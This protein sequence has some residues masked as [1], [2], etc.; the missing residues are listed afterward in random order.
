MT[1]ASLFSEN[2]ERWSQF[3]P[4]EADYLKHLVCNRISIKPLG[5]ELN[6]TLE[7]E[8]KVSFYHENDPIEEAK[9]WFEQLDVRNVTVIFVYGV[10]LGY[11]Y[12]AAKAWLQDPNHFLVFLED[13]LEVIYRLFETQRGKEI[14]F[15]KQVRLRF[16]TRFNMMDPIWVSLAETFAI[17]QYRVTALKHYAE[18]NSDIL[19]QIQVALSFWFSTNRMIH[20]EFSRYGQHFFTNL[21]QN[22]RLLPQ[23]YSANGLFGTFTGVPAII[24]GAGPSLTKNIETLKTLKNRALIFAGG[25]AMN[26]I[27]FSGFLPH[28][29]AGVD[30]NPAQLTRLIMNTAYEVPFFYR[31][32]MNHEALSLVQGP[33]LYV[34]GAGGYKISKW[35]EENLG[36]AGED[37]D[38][39]M[40]VINFSL[41]LA[42]A[43]GCNPIIFVGLD[44]AYSEGLSY[45]EGVTSHP[46]H[47]RRRD[48]L[49]KTSGDELLLKPDIYGKPVNTLWKWISESLWFGKF[50][51]ERSEIL[52]INATEGGIG[53]PGIPAKPLSEVAEHLLLRKSDFVLRVHGEV[54]NHAIP[55]TVTIEKI[56]LL[57]E[58]MFVSLKQSESYCKQLESLAEELIKRVEQGEEAP[59][60]LM[61]AEMQNIYDT[62]LQE[63]AYKFILNDL[64]DSFNPTLSLSHQQLAYD[65]FISAKES[66][67][68]KIMLFSERFKFLRNAAI[69]NQA[70]INHYVKQNQSNLHPQKSE[71]Q[72]APENK[73]NYFYEN[74]VLQIIDPELNI[75]IVEK[76][77]GYIETIFYPNERKKFEQ[78]LL[79]GELHGP[80]TFYKMDGTILGQSWYAHGKQQGKA[81]FYY[82]SGE[83]YSVQR[84]RDG[85][86][87]GM[88]HYYYSDGS[89]R[90]SLSYSK[91]ELDGIVQL[92][93]PNHTMKREQ[94]FVKGKRHGIER[95][96]NDSGILILEAEYHMGKPINKARTWHHNGQLSLEIEYDDRSNSISVKNWTKEGKLVEDSGEQKLDYYDTVAKQSQILTQSLEKVLKGL[97]NLAPILFPEAKERDQLQQE[98][99]NLEKQILHLEEMHTEML[100]QTL[101]KPETVNELIWKTPTV[102]TNIQKYLEEST[103]KL[104]KDIESIQMIVAKAAKEI[105]KKEDANG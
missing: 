75:N 71:P 53:M 79:N 80:V 28:F 25:S 86:F 62:L 92:F 88:Q 14:L 9:Q 102:Q 46:T 39:G 105:K 87:E 15:D 59:E 70:L 54:Q 27:N 40:N 4:N 103:K 77:K 16:F 84:F 45:H 50:A 67:M 42:F 98:L 43:L 78:H 55:E 93:H 38:E 65:F 56:Q 35:L 91:G 41:S 12:D 82:Y 81:L 69:M 1:P 83:L 60:N 20:S 21:Y 22:L 30:P 74:D 63:I 49:T 90:T 99:Q 24:C 36:I 66:T 2:L 76:G 18:N 23:A 31:S 95:M 57:I 32:R 64:D 44:L 37:V 10:G 52:F 47:D 5:K 104:K 11:Y 72:H 51:R 3:C 26:A 68:R 34:T 13:D 61:T 100:E 8:G 89:I 97:S 33:H 73:T 48:F 85:L 19:E 29:G 7:K 58:E 96:W 94:H 101:L 17:R 6:L